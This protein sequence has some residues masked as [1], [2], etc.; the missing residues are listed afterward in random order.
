M[1]HWVTALERIVNIL[2]DK[3][4]PDFERERHIDMLHVRAINFHKRQFTAQNVAT[5]LTQA[6][7]E[8]GQF[9]SRML[10]AQKV[11]RNYSS[12]MNTVNT[13][14]SKDYH[15]ETLHLRM[16][17]WDEYVKHIKEQANDVE[18]SPG[19][20]PVNYEPA[21]AQ[22]LPRADEANLG[23]GDLTPDP[24]STDSDTDVAAYGQ[25]YKSGVVPQAPSAYEDR[26]LKGGTNINRANRDFARRRSGERATR[27]PPGPRAVL[28][29]PGAPY[30]TKAKNNH[31]ARA[32]HRSIY[33]LFRAASRSMS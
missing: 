25:G 7:R 8:Y 28:A 10:E 21:L 13:L 29:K 27:P 31:R 32:P 23:E 30:P 24:Y 22:Y 5:L 18:Y 4:G 2:Q 19:V 16:K 9:L 14:S 12:Y 3:M 1:L 11:L 33:L 20:I 6:S 17:S 26:V 15:V